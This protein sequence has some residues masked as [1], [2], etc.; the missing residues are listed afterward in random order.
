MTGLS[1]GTVPAYVGS[2]V[3][4]ETPKPVLLY[5]KANRVVR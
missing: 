2:G 5:Q 3:I 4:P 1:A